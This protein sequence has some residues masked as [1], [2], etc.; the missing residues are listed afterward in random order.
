MSAN[1]AFTSTG[2]LPEWARLYFIISFRRLT[3][4][5]D[6]AL[7]VAFQDSRKLRMPLADMENSFSSTFPPT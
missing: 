3:C 2:M 6:T 4:A 1:F 7:S 5:S